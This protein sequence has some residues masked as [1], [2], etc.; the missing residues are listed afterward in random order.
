[1]LTKINLVL[2][3][4]PSNHPAKHPSLFS[5]NKKIHPKYKMG[6]DLQ[7]MDRFPASKHPRNR[8]ASDTTKKGHKHPNQKKKRGPTISQSENA[9][10][11]DTVKSL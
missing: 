9:S 6:D 10:K 11:K 1:M 4:H 8:R 2:F 7:S 5:G 3:C